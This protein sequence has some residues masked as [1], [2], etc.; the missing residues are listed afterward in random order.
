MAFLLL[1]ICLTSSIGVAQ[2]AKTPPV[3]SAPPNIEKA[4][5]ILQSAVTAL[6]A[7]NYLGVQSIV[8][9]GLY[10]AYKDSQPTLPLSFVD[11]IV[12]P[13]QERTEFKGEGFKTIQVN[14]GDTG[15][16]FDGMARTLKDLKPSQIS[17]FK[18][19]MRIN[20]DNLLRGISRKEG[21]KIEYAGRREA[22]VGKRNE[23]VRVSYPDGF[24]VEF[25]FGAV[26]HLPAKV[27]YFKNPE[28]GDELVREE[29][30]LAQFLNINGVMAPFVID[31]Y[32]AGVQ[33]SRTNYRTIE[34]NTP[35]ADTL[36]A[37]PANAK[38]IK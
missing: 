30:R 1:L 21:G 15:W 2:T 22:G 17:D 5:Q 7:G 28:E 11:Y 27:I 14:T 9:R 34:F 36:F 24:A 37:K 29:E 26:D 12:Y 3:K 33:T 31:H 23:A 25:E 20:V 16:I 8:G 38:A 4:E 32:S 6:G 19:A 35:I 18:L 13:D 10:T